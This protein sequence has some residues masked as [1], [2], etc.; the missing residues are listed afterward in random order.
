MLPP[1]LLLSIEKEQFEGLGERVPT[2]GGK[3]GDGG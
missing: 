3:I 2:T 1:G